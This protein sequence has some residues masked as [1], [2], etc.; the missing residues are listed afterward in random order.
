MMNIRSKEVI[1]MEMAMVRIDDKGRVIIPKRL[2]ENV[3]LDNRDYCYI[4]TFES[5][6]F[7]RKVDLDKGSILESIDKLKG[8]ETVER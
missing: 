1:T 4:Y 6:V 3:G 7:L 5:L 8:L 2:R